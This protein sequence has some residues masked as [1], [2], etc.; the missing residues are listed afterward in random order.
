MGTFFFSLIA[1]EEGQASA[2]VNVKCLIFMHTYAHV[3]TFV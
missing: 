3:T 2:K 1:S